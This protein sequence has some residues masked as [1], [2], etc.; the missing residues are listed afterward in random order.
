MLLL[1][2]VFALQCIAILLHRCS[3]WPPALPWT[4]HLITVISIRESETACMRDTD[5]V[6]KQE[7][8]QVMKLP[9][10]VLKHR[11]GTPTTSLPRLERRP[12][13]AASGGS[14]E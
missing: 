7:L 9:K 3:A 14:S 6:L 1:L 5:K 13:A 2:L 10:Q 12:A 4:M 11:N 8:K